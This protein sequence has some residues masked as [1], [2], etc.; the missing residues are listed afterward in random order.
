MLMIAIS[1]IGSFAAVMFSDVPSNHWAK[2]Y[3]TKMAD[4]KIISGYFDNHTL[5]VAFKPDKSVSYIEAIQMIYN[6]LKVA[7]K[8]QSN[9]GLTSKYASVLSVN[10]I[11]TWAQEAVAYTLEYN[12]VH[13][14]ELKVFI[15][16]GNSVYAKKVDIAVLIG[17]ALNMKLEA[18]PVL[19]FVDAETIKTAALP[20]VDLLEKNNIVGGD[21]LKKFNPNS[22]INRAVMA[23][24]CSKTYDLLASQTSP[25]I[26]SN[27]TVNTE[28][29][30]TIDYV[31]IDTKMIILKEKQGDKKAYALKS[32][33]IKKDGKYIDVSY[34]KTGD[35]VK[36]TFNSDGTVRGVKVIVG[37]SNTTTTDNSEK[38]ID[39]IDKNTRMVVVKNGKGDTEVYNLKLA[40]IKK[41]STFK[42][43]NDLKVGDGVKL[44]INSNGELVEIQ[45]H[46]EVT[47]MQARV[48][49][50][51][52]TDVGEYLLVVR[53]KNDLTIKK[54]L[55]MDKNTEIEY[56]DKEVDARYIQEGMEFYIKYIGQC[57]LK[58]EIKEEEK[59]YDGILESSVLF[60][61]GL[62]IKVKMNDG[63][64]KMFEIDED[65]VDVERNDKDAYLDELQKGDIVNFTVEY[66]KVKKIKAASRK[67]KKSR[68][69]GVIKQI[70]LGDP[71]TITIKNDDD[72][73]LTYDVSR[74]VEVRID[75]D[76][77]GDDGNYT[78][79]DLDIY[80][81]V[82]IRIENGQVYRIDADKEE[83]KESIKGEITRVYNDYDQLRVKYFDTLEKKYKTIYVRVKSGVKMIDLE[84]EK[85]E[86]RSLDEDD[87]ILIDGYYEDDMFIAE[88]IV[89]IK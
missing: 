68:E 80:Y 29:E 30:G 32:A 13:Q 72:E 70:I 11:P 9:V 65:D 27:P 20:Y 21:A 23:T 48:E 52:K 37:S 28:L 17:K 7:N 54:E 85:M 50:I 56:N 24:M 60:R 59:S 25:V 55:K 89:Q 38:I 40:R 12:I 69:N 67:D 33:Y 63:Q 26:P 42:S 2:P 15:K 78:L 88:R 4:K 71:S 6:T 1:T 34:L 61:D 62:S 57:A 86:L 14:D 45:I 18:I 53:D 22:I 77:D 73:M 64:V 79:K 16:N 44:I 75:G 5:K 35:P 49:S 39:Y 47:S 84:G 46:N 8:L 74:G 41:G 3:I 83:S 36:L 19:N 10:K 43:I 82:Q 58:I 66:G 51:E 76:N 81:E 31:S 87:E